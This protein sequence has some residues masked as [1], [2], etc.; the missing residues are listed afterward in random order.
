MDTLIDHGIQS[1]TMSQYPETYFP[2]LTQPNDDDYVAEGADVW[3]YLYP[4]PTISLP[5]G[6][7]GF[8]SVVAWLNYNALIV[9]NVQYYDNNHYNVEISYGPYG[10]TMNTN[11]QA[12]QTK[13]PPPKYGSIADRETPYL[14]APGF[15][16]DPYWW[17]VDT[18][19][20]D[21]GG[22]EDK[23]WTAGGG[24]SLSSPVAAG[25]ATNVIA[26]GT[27]GWPEKTRAILLAT[28][29]NVDSGYWDPTHH[30][31]RD[32]AGTISGMNA[33]AF[34]TGAADLTGV[35]SPPPYTDAYGGFSVD[36]T[37]FGEDG[38]V[39][40][41]YYSYA[42]PES[43]PSGYH[44]RIVLTWDSAPGVNGAE[45]EVSDLGLYAST[46]GE[47][48]VSDSWNGN[49]EMIDIPN[50]AL[51]PNSSYNVWVTPNIFREPSPLPN[52]SPFT[53]YSIAWTWVKDHAN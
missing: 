14:V 42:T 39:T 4:Y 6:D 7:F 29:Q 35:V 13:N 12:S 34:T 3:A 32:G 41:I 24:T 47:V 38:H 18:C 27:W 9:G 37:Y 25:I 19:I 26:A 17:M 46:D 40:P 51:T 36:S 21:S 2:P 53:Y 45:N 22:Y 30:D 8:D 43:L 31:G 15:T 44:L 1:V 20:L 28:A 33:V 5:S 11:W 50:Y 23:Y 16:P 49:I 10:F 48:F 52:G